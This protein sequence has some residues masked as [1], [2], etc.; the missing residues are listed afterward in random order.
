MTLDKKEI[1]KG[2][3]ILERGLELTDKRRQKKTDYLRMRP[4][5]Y[6]EVS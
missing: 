3:K 4:A 5:T 2:Y 1:E 6:E